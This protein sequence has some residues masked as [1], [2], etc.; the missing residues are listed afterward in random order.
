MPTVRRRCNGISAAGLGATEDVVKNADRERWRVRGFNISLSGLEN[1]PPSGPKGT[2][3]NRNYRTI[4]RSGVRAVLV[5][6]CE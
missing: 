4:R 3:S 6:V 2:T 1:G 5:C